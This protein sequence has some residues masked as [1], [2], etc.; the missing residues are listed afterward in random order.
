VSDV[1]QTSASW[2][3]VDLAGL[4]ARPATRPT[5]GGAGLVYP[6]KRHLFS[7]APESAKTIAAY[8]IALDEI[9]SDGG[10]LL[11]DF[12]MGRWDARDRLREMGATDRDLAR[13]LYVEPETPA[14]VEVVANLIESWTFTLAIIDASAGAYALQGLDDNQ[15]RDVETFARLYVQAFQR[16]DIASIVL[17]HVTKKRDDRGQFAI[18]SERKVGGVDVHLGFETVLP[19]ARGGRGLYKL[20]THKDRLGH[21]PRPKAAEMELRSDAATHAITWTFRP[22]APDGT[23]WKPTVLM[24]KV[25]LWL[26]LQRDEVSRHEVERNVVGKGDYKR[27]ALDA[28]ITEGYVLETA[29]PRGSRPVRSL[30]PYRA[31]GDGDE[32]GTKWDEVDGEPRATSSLAPPVY[33]GDEDEVER[34]EA[35][36]R[37]MQEGGA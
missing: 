31:P 34:L 16:R 14:S 23:G 12:E 11:L 22:P 21:L 6:G 9:R 4:E 17:D 35:I 8:A 10:V 18:G 27:A 36:W 5:V 28:L 1:R 33:T 29:G 32:V 19:I 7:G 15:R 20:T 30:R 13:L 26:E 37:E 3:P 24:E 2:E 25:S